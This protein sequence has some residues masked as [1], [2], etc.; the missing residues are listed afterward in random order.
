MNSSLGDCGKCQSVVKL[1]VQ[2]SECKLWYHRKCEGIKKGEYIDKCQRCR[3]VSV[4][5]SS[6][7]SDGENDCSSRGCTRCP[8]LEKE[9]TAEKSKC[10]GL[11]EMN[12]ELLT[13]IDKL[14]V[15][16]QALKR[17][18]KEREWTTVVN[19][20][21]NPRRWSDVMVNNHGSSL[22]TGNRFNVLDAEPTPARPATQQVSRVG[23]Q[24]GKK[25]KKKVLLLSS[26]QGRMCSNLL[27]ERLGDGYEVS[28]IVKPNARL[29]EV[30]G[31]V[32]NLVA[33]FGKEDCLIVLGG[34]NDMDGNY[35]ETIPEGIRRVLPLSKKTNVIFNSVLTRFDR[36][37]LRSQVRDANHIIHTEVNKCQ[38]KK[39]ANI[40]INFGTER[41]SRECYT[42]HGLHLNLVGKTELCMKW[43]NLVLDCVNKN[44]DFLVQTRATREKR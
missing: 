19:R 9:V 23:N 11:E 17:M 15:E 40:R 33:N 22:V 30:V 27:Q 36:P 4:A 20:T 16:L 2:C 26:S 35:K 13:K 3:S 38:D 34:T 39:S 24:D 7:A 43:S 6:E 31:D 1:G 5:E 10:K 25:K 42:K 18:S 29:K 12:A 44:S 41:L 8:A 28:S 21:S 32:D 37:E 14:N